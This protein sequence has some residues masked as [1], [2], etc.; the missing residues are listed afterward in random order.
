MLFASD[1]TVLAFERCLAEAA[2]LP[3][4]EGVLERYLRDNALA[5]F[6]WD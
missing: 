2:A 5:L 6:R 1:H 3:L 4:R